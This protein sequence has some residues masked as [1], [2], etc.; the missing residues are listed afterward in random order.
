MRHLRRAPL[1][2]IGFTLSSS[3]FAAVGTGPIAVPEPGSIALVAIGL[4]G[5]L[6]A[7]RAARRRKDKNDR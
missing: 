4:V 6:W 2:A 1:L 7:G 3:V 5:A